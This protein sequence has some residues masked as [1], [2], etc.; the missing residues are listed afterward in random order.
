MGWV[1]RRPR[2]NCSISNGESELDGA[3]RERPDETGLRIDSEY[4]LLSA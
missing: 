3:V 1:G 4:V 2:G